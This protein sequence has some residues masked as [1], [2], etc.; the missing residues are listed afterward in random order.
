MENQKR[1]VESERKNLTNAIAR[2]GSGIESLTERLR[3]SE[4]ALSR[5]SNQAEEL[6]AEI[7]DIDDQVIDEQDLRDALSAF[8]EL[9]SAMTTSEQHRV[10]LLLIEAVTFDGRE[11]QI[12]IQFRPSGIRCLADSENRVP[13]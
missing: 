3:E 12:S 5:I 7:R 8:D 13:R 4:E 9:W 2:D 11:A 1:R 6:K 10:L